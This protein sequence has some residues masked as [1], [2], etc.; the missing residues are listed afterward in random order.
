MLKYLMS[1]V[2]VLG[3]SLTGCTESVAEQREDLAEEKVEAV[4]EVNEEAA[5]QAADVAEAKEDLEQTK[6]EVND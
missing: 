3:L 5:D 6:A 2:C 1:L 4:N